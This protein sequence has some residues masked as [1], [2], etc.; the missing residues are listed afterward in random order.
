M[1]NITTIK[2]IPCQEN[3]VQRAKKG[4][5]ETEQKWWFNRKF[6]ALIV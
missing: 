1:K 5:K 6:I 2:S 4:K 3:P